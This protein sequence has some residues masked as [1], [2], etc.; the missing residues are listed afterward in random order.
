MRADR[1]LDYRPPMLSAPSGTAWH[2]ALHRK[3]LRFHQHSAAQAAHAATSSAVSGE[4][5]D[6]WLGEPA[7]HSTRIAVALGNSYVRASVRPVPTDGN[8][9]E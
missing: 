2:C 3:D 1:F 5:F 6:S 7:G 4:R 9:A 8:Q